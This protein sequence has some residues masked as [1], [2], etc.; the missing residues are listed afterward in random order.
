MKYRA[1]PLL[2]IWLFLFATLPN[3]Q[4]QGGYVN[5]T[6]YSG[7]NLICNSFNNGDNHL[8]TILTSTFPDLANNSSISLWDPVS[9]QFSLPS[10]YTPGSGWSINYYLPLG[11]GAVFRT[12]AQLQIIT[13][14]SVD[15][16]V[17]HDPGVG[18]F[19]LSSITP[20]SAATFQQ[21]VGRDP[22]QG[23]SVRRLDGPSQTYFTTT[24]LGEDQWDNGTP[25]ITYGQS[26]FYTL[27]SEP[28]PEPGMLAFA[29]LASVAVLA[30]QRYRRAKRLR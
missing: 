14:G 22:Q 18:T 2:C 29:G 13:V 19:L 11:L 1:L 24:Y 28:V 6:L 7:D 5:T 17:P 16:S 4:A 30:A 9:Q 20:Y 27:L 10:I 21:V 26:A 25:T 12:E 23:E 15:F 3:L 8:N